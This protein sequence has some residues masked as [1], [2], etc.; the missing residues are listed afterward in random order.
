M[1]AVKFIAFILLVVL[2]TSDLLSIYRALNDSQT[3]LVVFENTSEEEQR[4]EKES[5]EK[6]LIRKTVSRIFRIQY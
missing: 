4:E 2:T 6:E 1:K 5:E 3:T